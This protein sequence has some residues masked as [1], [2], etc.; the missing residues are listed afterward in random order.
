MSSC[1][2]LHSRLYRIKNAMLNK[3]YYYYLF[4]RIISPNLIDSKYKENVCSIFNFSRS[5]IK[6]FENNAYR[7][8]YDHPLGPNSVVMDMGGF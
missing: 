2:K 6:W 5:I 3:N 8:L 4:K 7:K 1:A